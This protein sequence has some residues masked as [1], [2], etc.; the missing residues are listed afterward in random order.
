MYSFLS[1]ERIASKQSKLIRRYRPKILRNDKD[2]QVFIMGRPICAPEAG[3]EVCYLRLPYLLTVHAVKPDV[4]SRDRRDD[5]TER[6]RRPAGRT[7]RSGNRTSETTSALRLLVYQ[8]THV[9]RRGVYS[10]R[11]RHHRQWESSTLA[12]SK[13]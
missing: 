6:R 1:S 11:P 8:S 7:S 12:K 10:W 13:G 3:G 5:V 2:Q 4:G 9:N